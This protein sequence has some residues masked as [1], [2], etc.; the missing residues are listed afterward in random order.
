MSARDRT[1]SL[2]ETAVGG[3]IADVPTPVPVVDLDRVEANVRRLSEYARAHSI[4]LWPHTKTHKSTI[5]G[6]LQRDLGAAGLTVAKTGEAEVFADSD[7]GP[8]LM[9][10][11]PLGTAVW[12]R[13]A[14]VA[15]SVPLTIALDSL[16]SAEGL[17]AALSS[18][19]VRAEVL[20]ELDT[21]LRRTGLGD[22]AAAVALAQEVDRLPALAVAGISTYPG[23][24]RGTPEELRPGLRELD[25]MLRETADGFERVGLSCERISGGSTPTR[26]LT[27][28]TCVT[29]LRAGT[30]VFLDRQSAASEPDLELDACALTVEVSVVST[31]VPGRIAIDAGS[32]TLTSDPHPAGGFGAVVGHPELSIVALNEE[33]GYIELGSSEAGFAVGDRVSVIPNHVCACVNLHDFLLGARDG[34]IEQLVEVEAR[35]LIR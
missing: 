22:V 5:F 30:A 21:G 28:E 1:L 26:Y 34:A 24:L 19:G 7:L 8:L 31:S 14:R 25:S 11:P 33:H 32:K 12:K 20:I 23:H 9:H 13:L 6:R 15:A 17:S 10:F 3:G 27:H 35:G 2:L 16:V 29:E 4:E 18:A